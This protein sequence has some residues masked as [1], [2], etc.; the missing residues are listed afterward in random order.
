MPLLRL[1]ILVGI[2]VAPR[3]LDAQ[4]AAS[5]APSA[6]ERDAARKKAVEIA[7]KVPKDMGL[8]NRTKYVF[9]PVDRDDPASVLEDSEVK[10]FIPP[11]LMKTDLIMVLFVPEKLGTGPPMAVFV[12]P[13]LGVVRGYIIGPKERPQ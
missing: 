11:I 5:P 7:T 10:P 3:L 9:F 13:R 12:D 1:F 4:V 2:V 6:S 8:L